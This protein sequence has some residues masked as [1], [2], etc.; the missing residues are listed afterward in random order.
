VSV[1]YFHCTDGV[2]FF[3]DEE[4]SRVARDEEVFLAAMK[5]AEAVMR[6][7]PAH[8]WSEWLVC[9]YD[10]LRQMVDVFNFPAVRALA[11]LGRVGPVGEWICA[12][13]RGAL[14]RSRRLKPH[15]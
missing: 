13:R 12:A 8:D 10:D 9:V 1:H 2:S 11:S 4:G 5:R 15:L 6:E 14:P 7:L 3:A